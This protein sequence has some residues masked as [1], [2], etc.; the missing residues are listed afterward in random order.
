MPEDQPEI[1]SKIVD[2]ARYEQIR[3]AWLL[4]KKYIETNNRITFFCYALSEL[5]PKSQFIHLV[6]QPEAFITSGLARDWY[7]NSVLHD[8]GRIKPTDNELQQVEKIAWLW[9][10]TNHFIEQFKREI[11]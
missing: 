9:N 2:A 11:P 3:N 7:S 1:V 8:E 6:R 5:F 10:E 4:D